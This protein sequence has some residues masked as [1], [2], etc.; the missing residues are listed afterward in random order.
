VIRLEATPVKLSW[1]LAQQ[2]EAQVVM[3]LLSLVRA[4]VALVAPWYS[5]LAILAQLRLLA[6]ASV[7]LR[8][9]GLPP[10]VA[11]VGLSLLRV[12]QEL[13]Q[14]E[15]PCFSQA[16]RARQAIAGKSIWRLLLEA[17]LAYLVPSSFIPVLRQ[18]VILA[19]YLSQREAGLV[20]QA[21]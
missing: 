19:R 8:E 3:F 12:E 14:L 2:Q 13:H 10:R 5:V 6:V 18:E 4:L 7:S 9:M 15:V 17:L 20:R 16:A 1:V 11:L 21:P